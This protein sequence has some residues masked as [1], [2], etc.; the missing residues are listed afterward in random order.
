MRSFYRRDELEREE[1]DLEGEL[2]G[3]HDEGEDIG[4]ED[5]GVDGESRQHGTVNTLYILI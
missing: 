2:E 5:D 4:G 3:D 1:E